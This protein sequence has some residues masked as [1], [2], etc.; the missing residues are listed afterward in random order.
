MEAIQTKTTTTHHLSLEEQEKH[1]DYQKSLHAVLPS[2]NR[3]NDT[4]VKRTK[5]ELNKH[6]SETTTQKVQ[7][8]TEKPVGSYPIGEPH[9][10]SNSIAEQPDNAYSDV[11]TNFI[12]DGQQLPSNNGSTYL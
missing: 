3:P 5:M 12:D 9:E 10:T 6:D 2:F 7:P 8:K 1:I 4:A 11:Y